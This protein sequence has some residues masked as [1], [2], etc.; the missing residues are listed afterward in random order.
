MNQIRFFVFITDIYN[1]IANFDF[2][3]YLRA[4]KSIS[5]S[6]SLLSAIFV[7]AMIFKIRGLLKE[8]I[9]NMAREIKPPAEAKTEADLR[10]GEIKSHANSFSEAE[11]KL[12]VI[13]ADKFVDDAL[14]ISGFQGESM[15]ER[16]MIIQP[17]Q[18]LSLQELWDAHKLRN[19]LVHEVKYQ[20]SHRQVVLAVESFEKTLRELGAIT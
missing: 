2:S 15:G 11:W 13:E 6:V 1:S 19:L 10:W 18:L 17:G 7:G 5:F 4:I 20:L 8:Q 14:K 3:G 12:A 9:L 16:L